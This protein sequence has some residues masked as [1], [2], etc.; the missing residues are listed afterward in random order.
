MRNINLPKTRVY[1][2]K[3]AFGGPD[4]KFEPAWL[5]SVRAVRNRPFVFQV[6]VDAFAACYDKIPPHCLYWYE[7]DGDQADLPLHKIQMWECLSGSVELWQKAQ[8]ADVPVLVN[9]GRDMKP[10]GGHYWFTMDFLPENAG[11]GYLDVGDCELLE[12]HKEANVVKLSNGQIAIYPNNRL[13]WLPI[14][15]TPEGAAA[16]IPDWKVATNEQWDD[17]WQDSTEVLGSNDQW[18]Y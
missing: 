13:K 5:V 11:V 17:W 8:L 16:K 3:D 9:L 1:V 10:I 7:P 14:S 12:E 15:L 6:W 18:A 4:N 2:R